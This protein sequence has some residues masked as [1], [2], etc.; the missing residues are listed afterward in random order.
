MRVAVL[1]AFERGIYLPYAQEEAALA[2]KFYEARG[3]YKYF[4]LYSGEKR[5]CF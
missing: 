3:L 2:E 1:Q 5:D 4:E